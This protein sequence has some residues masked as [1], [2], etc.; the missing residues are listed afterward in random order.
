MQSRSAGYR[1]KQTRAQHALSPQPPTTP[2]TTPT[3][4]PVLEGLL[5]E[6]LLGQGGSSPAVLSWL[7]VRFC[8]WY[9][10]AAGTCELGTGPGIQMGTVGL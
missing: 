7:V 1:K 2:T 9:T 3:M 4:K 8:D 10:G 6:S 5:D